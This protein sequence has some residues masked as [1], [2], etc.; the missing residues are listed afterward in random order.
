VPAAADA[1]AQITAHPFLG[2]KIDLL[3]KKSFVLVS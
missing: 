3:R 2:T 1:V